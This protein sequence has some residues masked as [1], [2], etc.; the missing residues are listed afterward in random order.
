MDF[1]AIVAHFNFY[2]ENDEKLE[3]TLADNVEDAVTLMTI[4]GSKG[5]EF[6]IVYFVG[7]SSQF[8]FFSADSY[9]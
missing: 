1:A 4:H 2:D 6:P 9:L 7:F 8:N 3:V 5:L